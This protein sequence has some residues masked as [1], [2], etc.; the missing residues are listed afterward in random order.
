M[1]AHAHQRSAVT[2]AKSQNKEFY[3]AINGKQKRKI[4]KESFATG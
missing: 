1:F 4:P 3:L 2:G